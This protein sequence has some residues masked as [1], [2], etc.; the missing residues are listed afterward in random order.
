MPNKLT[1]KEQHKLYVINKAIAHTITNNQAAKQLHLSVRQVKRL[2]QQVR[3]HG[4]KAVIHKLKGETS[5]HAFAQQEKEKIVKT[6]ADNYADFKP[7]FAA[8]KLEE[9]HSIYVSRE[10]ARLWMTEAGIWKPHKQKHTGEYHSW[11][12]RKEYFGEMVQFDGSYHDWFEDRFVDAQ[13]NPIEVCLLAAIDDATGEITK[14]VFA[15]NEGVKAVFTFYK[16][17]VLDKGKPGTV[18]LDK[19]STYKINHKAAVDNSELMTQFQR[20]TKDLRIRLILANSPQAKGR[21]ERLFKTLQD[22]LIKEMRLSKINTPEEGNTFLHEVFIP[23][24]NKKFGVVAAKEGDLHE[25]LTKEDKKH[26]NRIFSVQSIRR[27]NNDFTIQFKNTWYQLGEVQPVTIRAKDTVL[28]EEWLDDTRHV[29]YKREYLH[30]FVL[31]ERP[32]KQKENPTILT[33]HSL[34]YKPPQNHPWR[35]YKQSKS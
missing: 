5:N 12:P 14:A 19:F 21:V 24:F 34:N 11:R 29:S 33:T 31:P 26:L 18:Y 2:K 25:P 27:V 3:L 7:T 23:K 32:K 22:R 30:F 9:K 8:E 6:I 16:E 4:E 15:K 1:E 13:G 17:Y 35:R 20:A 10:T 28:V